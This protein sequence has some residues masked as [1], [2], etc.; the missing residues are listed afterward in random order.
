MTPQE[1]LNL[2]SLRGLR[3]KIVRDEV[4]INVCVFCG[5]EKWNCEVNAVRG[6]YHAWCCG[7]SGRTQYFVRDF[8]G[9]DV[10]VP[11]LPFET[12]R[13]R[14]FTGAPPEVYKALESPSV[15]D[16]LKNRG[17]DFVDFNIYEVGE[18]SGNT[19][20]GRAVFHLREYWSR[21]SVGYMGR[22]VHSAIRPKYFAHWNSGQKQ[23]SGYL[24]KSTT[25]V[26]VEG[27]FD[28]IKVNQAGY[29]AAV[30][31]GV[32]EKQVEEWAGRVKESHTIV[33]MLDGDAQ[34]QARKL[35]WRIYPIHT[36]TFVATLLEGMDPAV[37]ERTTIHELIRRTAK[38]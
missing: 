12:K 23:I 1:L 33:V 15:I 20:G 27:I 34:E 3:A 30:L 38:C 2:C 6:L 21:E 22:A 13:K 16:Y 24:S 26:V 37:L 14:T 31:G 29:N 5:N 19:W 4:A 35:Y 36:N 9:A 18:G 28:G 32:H 17:L 11:V 7:A 10:N 25:H 8:L